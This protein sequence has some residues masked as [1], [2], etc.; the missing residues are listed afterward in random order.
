[1][2]YLVKS[3]IVLTAKYCRNI[4]RQQHVLYAFSRA[5]NDPVVAM[6]LMIGQT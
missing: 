6:N 5:G 3:S 2:A 1:M 4:C